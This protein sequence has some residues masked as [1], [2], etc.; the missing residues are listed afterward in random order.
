[1]TITKEVNV[2]V[3]AQKDMTDLEY[4]DS[5]K[6][7]VTDEY[8]QNALDLDV[9]NLLK[10]DADRLLAGFRETAGYASGMSE[11]DIK[12]Y[13]KNKERYEGGWENALIGGHTLGHYMSAAA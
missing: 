4:F 6:V 10:L 9:Q 3:T 11:K 13:M 1:M 2:T 8:Y 7:T 5:G 12:T